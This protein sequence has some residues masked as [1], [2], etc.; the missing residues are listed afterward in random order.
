[1]VEP[2]HLSPGLRVVASFAAKLRAVRPLPLHAV[3]KLSVMWI[4]VTRRAA[5]VTKVERQY[6]IRASGGANLVAVHAGNR[7]VR[8]SQRIL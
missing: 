5:L 4:R 3:P 7:D 2:F 8:A 1:M 6:F